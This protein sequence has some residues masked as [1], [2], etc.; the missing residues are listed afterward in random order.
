VVLIYTNKSYGTLP[1]LRVAPI[2]N[3]AKWQ[4]QQNHFIYK[5]T[6]EL[7]S[8]TQNTLPSVLALIFGSVISLI[9]VIPQRKQQ[10]EWTLGPASPS[11][12]FSIYVTDCFVKRY[13]LYE[14]LLHRIADCTKSLWLQAVNL[15]L[16]RQIGHSFSF[17]CFFDISGIWFWRGFTYVQQIPLQFQLRPIFDFPKSTA[18]SVGMLFAK[19]SASQSNYRSPTVNF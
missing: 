19:Q 10:R 1:L 4:G 9:S 16:Y 8:V 2:N 3:R 14:R 7:I 13:W 17:E 11:W 15:G 12:Y 18:E 6:T 5:S